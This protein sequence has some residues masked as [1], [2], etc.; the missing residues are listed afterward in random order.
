MIFS[1]VAP[2]ANSKS[3]RTLRERKVT[4]SSAAYRESNKNEEDD[5]D[6]NG[7]GASDDNDADND[8]EDDDDAQAKI[9]ELVL[10]KNLKIEMGGCEDDDG[11]EE[12]N[13]K[14]Y[15]SACERVVVNDCLMST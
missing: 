14:E 10:M 1:S 8:E 6:D 11:E 4:P 7:V 12:E 15:R 9:E 5:D 3:G 2:S 13:E